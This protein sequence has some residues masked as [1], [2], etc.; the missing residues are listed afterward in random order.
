MY[1]VFFIQTK[2]SI[3]Q[4]FFSENYKDI[5]HTAYAFIYYFKSK[6]MGFFILI[7]ENEVYGYFWIIENESYYLIN[8]FVI[9]EVI[10]NFITCKNRY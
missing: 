1:L 8:V 10:F 9:V 7:I 6:I 3:S 2:K 4:F 5:L